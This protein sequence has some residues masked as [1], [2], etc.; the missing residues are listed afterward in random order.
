MSPTWVS[1]DPV[2]SMM[3]R[4]CSDWLAWSAVVVA[5]SDGLPSLALT[6]DPS[7][8]GSCSFLHFQNS[9]FWPVIKVIQLVP[10]K[11]LDVL[12]PFLAQLWNRASLSSVSGSKR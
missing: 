1:R 4:D 9:R 7:K 2:A 8:G 3:Y 11:V 6:Q 10:P 12:M 5:K